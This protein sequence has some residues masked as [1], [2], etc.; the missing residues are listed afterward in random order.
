MKYNT[1]MA[2][3]QTIF[4]DFWEISPE[5]KLAKQATKKPQQKIGAFS[6]FNDKTN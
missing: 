3:K 2:D 4:P 1:T 5:E 6:F